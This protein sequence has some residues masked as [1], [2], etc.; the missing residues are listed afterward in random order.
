MSLEH[1]SVACA[2]FCELLLALDSYHLVLQ[3]KE[4][5][6]MLGTMDINEFHSTALDAM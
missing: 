4:Q 2:H 1:S 6:V 3:D 5:K